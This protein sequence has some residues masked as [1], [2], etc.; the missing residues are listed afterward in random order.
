M[1]MRRIDLGEVPYPEA[2]ESMAGWVEERRAG[3]APDRLFLL[4]HPAVI[5]YGKNTAP[6]DLPADAAGR[7]LP[8]EPIIRDTLAAHL[9]AASVRS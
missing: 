6:S 5:T 3:L 8:P 9:G 4:S 7:P 1:A 2:L